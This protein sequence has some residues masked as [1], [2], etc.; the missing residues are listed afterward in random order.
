MTVI[1]GDVSGKG[2]SAA[3]YLFKIQGILRSLYAFGLT[4]RE[5]FI[6]ANQLLYRD[7]E[8][9]S[10]VTAIGGFF[11]TNKHRLILARAGHLPLFYY[12]SMGKKVEKITPK[13]LGLGLDKQ[14]IFSAEIEEKTIKYN[15]GDVFVFITD[16]IVEALSVD[17]RE[18]G[19]ENLIKV[20]EHNYSENAKNIRDK[21][22]SEVNRFSANTLQHDDQTVVVV[23][24]I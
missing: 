15:K 20:L 12:Q 18:F 23:K 19:E 13:G 5:L 17:G 10:F 22:I 21:I 6:R 4:P 8:K 1:V 16:G 9:K 3:L 24:A 7:L 14:D 2:T 11:E